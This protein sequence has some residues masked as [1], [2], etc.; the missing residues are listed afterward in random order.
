V[1]EP[2]LP[3]LRR[4]AFL[5]SG[6]WGRADELVLRTLTGAAVAGRRRCDPAALRAQLIR[7]WTADRRPAPDAGR[8]ERPE[9]VRTLLRMPPRQRACVVLRYWERCGVEETA[10][11]LDCSPDEVRRDTTRG[12]EALVRL[13]S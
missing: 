1:R 10:R 9:L 6:D 8:G 4:T 7:C 13:R 12:L 11:L 2:D 3:A 5:L